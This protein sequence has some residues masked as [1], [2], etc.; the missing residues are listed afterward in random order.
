[1]GVRRR[2]KVQKMLG[3]HGKIT[4]LLV[5][6]KWFQILIRR[7]KLVLAI[8]ETDN[9]NNLQMCYFRTIAHPKH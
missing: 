9:P 2:S 4:D 5:A 1:M 8:L 7:K 6:G 3:L